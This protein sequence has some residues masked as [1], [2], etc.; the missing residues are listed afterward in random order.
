MRGIERGGKHWTVAR[1]KDSLARV[2]AGSRGDAQRLQQRLSQLL[3]N[4]DDDAS[5][6][7]V[8]VAITEPAPLDAMPVAQHGVAAA[9]VWPRI[10]ACLGDTLRCR[11]RKL[12]RKRWPTN[13]ER[14]V[15]LWR[16]MARRR[17]WPTA[18]MPGRSARAGC[19]RTV[20]ICSTRWARWPRN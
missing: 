16:P 6:A 5:G 2:L 12:A 4:W 17:R 7:K 14:C 19:L 1:R 9:P 11:R 13:C 8:D 20:I 15:R 3:A 18:S 10:A